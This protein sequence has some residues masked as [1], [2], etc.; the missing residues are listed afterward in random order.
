MANSAVDLSQFHGQWVAIDAYSGQVVGHDVSKRMLRRS[1]SPAQRHAAR[2][3]YVQPI[4][5]SDAS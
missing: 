4:G 2:F 3:V 5:D 1:L